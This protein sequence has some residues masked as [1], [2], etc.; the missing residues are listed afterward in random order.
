MRTANKVSETL[1]ASKTIILDHFNNFVS[2]MT[3]SDSGSKLIVAKDLFT[4]ICNGTRNKAF[5]NL[6]RNTHNRAA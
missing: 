2:S 5:G 1:L 4:R 3:V 6:L